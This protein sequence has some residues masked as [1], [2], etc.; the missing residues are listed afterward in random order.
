MTSGG[1]LANLTALAAA[2][3]AVGP[4]VCYLSDQTHS[5]IRARCARSGF[6]RS[7][8]AC[9][10]RRAAAAAARRPRRRRRRRRGGRVS[11]LGRGRHRRHDQHRRRRSAAGARRPV[12]R[13]GPVAA[14][15]R[16]LRRRGRARASRPAGSWPASSAPTRWSSTRTSGSSSPTTSAACWWPAGR[17]R[18]GLPH[19]PEYL[20]DVH[21]PAGEVDLHD[22]G[23][24]LT[25]RARGAEA[26]ADLP[27]L[28]P[29]RAA[30]AS[31]GAR[32]WRSTPS[33]WSRP[34]ALGGRHAGA[35]RRS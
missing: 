13:R 22:R 11:A 24:E 15:R 25:R 2:R 21:G 16:C 5:S 23:L 34:T 10:L 9:C 1:S 12:P 14:R 4:G 35:A 3:A 19:D 26:V 29:G 20:A 33:G 28:R 17:A 8:S 6:P 27:H 30:A 31:R 7:R 32:G 18:A